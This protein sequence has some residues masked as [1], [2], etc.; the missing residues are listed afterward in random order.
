VIPR[1]VFDTN[2]VISALLFQN[3]RLAWL[4]S[5]WQSG[6][7][8]PLA[9]RE[10]VAELMRVLA[11]PKFRLV[12]DDHLELLSSYLPCCEIVDGTNTSAVFCR[13]DADQKFLDLAERGRA[14][15]LIT[16]D[17]DL[18]SLKDQV[19]F[20]IETPASY[21]DRIVQQSPLEGSHLQG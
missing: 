9:S 17:A 8:I 1:T 14:D 2:T 15:L 5:H 4:R 20:V 7:C 3:G 21:R 12:I 19:S 18:L 10:T 6:E 16:G 13:N 11:Y